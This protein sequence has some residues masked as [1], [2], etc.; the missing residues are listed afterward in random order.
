MISCG[1]III[2]SLLGMLYVIYQEKEEYK[3]IAGEKNES[4]N[5]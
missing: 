4:F 5:D 1:L 2:A 3:L